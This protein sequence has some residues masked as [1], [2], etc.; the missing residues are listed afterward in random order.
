MKPFCCT[1]SLR[2][3]TEGK[4]KQKKTES[5]AQRNYG[6][7]ERREQKIIALWKKAAQDERRLENIHDEWFQRCNSWVAAVTFVFQIT[8]LSIVPLYY[9][10]RMQQNWNNGVWQNNWIIPDISSIV[11]IHKD[12]SAWEKDTELDDR[13]FHSHSYVLQILG[14]GICFEVRLKW[15]NNLKSRM[16][17]HEDYSQPNG[18]LKTSHP[19]SR[20]LRSDVTAWSLTNSYTHT[21]KRFIMQNHNR[22]LCTTSS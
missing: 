5:W 6:A 21:H 3:K 8:H 7:Q 17:A 12:Y 14:L 15:Q 18:L 16:Q 10:K 1:E 2:G 9:I 22:N 13:S 4:K 11:K 19:F 20:Q